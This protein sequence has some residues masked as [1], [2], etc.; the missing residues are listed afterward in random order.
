MLTTYF[1]RQ[2][3][4]ATYYAGSAG[5]YL[6]AFTHWLAQRGYRHETIRRRLQGAAQFVTWAHTTACPLTSLSPT[7]LE[8]FRHH[9]AQ[10][11]QLRTPGG[12]HA[13]RWLGAQHF[14]A[15]LQA[16]QI[17]APVEASQE[18]V[19][20]ALLEAF[21]QWMHVHRGVKPSTLLIY[22]PHILALLTALGTCP[23]Q[24]DVAQARTGILADARHRSPALVKKRVTACRMLLRFLSATGR[25]RPGLEAALPTI[26]S[27]RLTTWPRYLP[28][29]DVDRV[30]AACESTTARGLRDKAIVLLLARLGLRAGEVAGLQLDDID[31]AQ[32]TFRVIGKSRREAKLPLPQDVGD[33]MLAYL[34]AARPTVQSQAIFMTAIAPWTPITRYVVTSVAV[35]AIQRAGVEAPSL[36]AHVLRHSTATGLLRQGA[37]RQVLGEVLRH[38]AVDTTAQ[39]AKVDV[40]LLQYVTMPWPGA[41][42]C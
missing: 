27:W 19:H 31:W 24:W 13:V 16:Q 33:A 8:R 5:P 18:T 20:P 26:A 32:G 30:I 25:C 35:R 9:L 7:T 10:Q 22:R 29:E 12:Q 17:I 41:P 42:S 37:S 23:E 4:Q 39:Y 11:G 15:F 38:R 2:T 34:D 6:D 21:E 1:T 40:G 28:P 14:L 3:T 36:G